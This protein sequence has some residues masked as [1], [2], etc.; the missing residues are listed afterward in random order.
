V[1]GLGLAALLCALHAPAAW[2]LT[3]AQVYAKVA[4]LVVVVEAHDAQGSKR[5]QGSGVIIAPGEVVTN[6]HV[7]LR[8]ERI[9]VLS[10]GTRHAATRR[11]ADEERDLC[12]LQVPGLGALAALAPL[13][14]ASPG[15][16]VFAIGAPQGLELTLSD[17]LI[18]GLREINGI[19]V[20]Q[21][22]APISPGSSGGGLFN[23][24]GHLVGI[25]TFQS[26]SGQN[27]NFA[28]PARSIGEL[29]ARHARTQGTLASTVFT[30]EWQG[31]DA[32]RP[33]LAETAAFIEENVRAFGRTANVPLSDGATMEIVL[34]SIAVRDCRMRME[35]ELVTSR[36][37]PGTAPPSEVLLDIVR[38]DVKGLTTGLLD[39]ASGVTLASEKTPFATRRTVFPAARKFSESTENRFVIY[40]ADPAAARRVRNALANLIVLCEGRPG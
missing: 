12:Q 4:K 1:K 31:Q 25:T 7:A 9:V 35:R 14:G 21:T 8:G 27:L 30:D 20:L 3:P 17:G 28:L 33:G 36:A 13:A 10:A 34:G 37:A 32:R 40:L 19:S 29:A 5:A 22:T 23:D 38:F 15:D 18:S 26:R 24:A 6:C 16:H 2:P 11:Y 39:P